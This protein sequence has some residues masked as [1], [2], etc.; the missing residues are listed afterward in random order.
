MK[1][2]FFLLWGVSYVHTRH[3]NPWYYTHSSLSFSQIMHS[4]YLTQGVCICFRLKQSCDFNSIQDTAHI[5]VFNTNLYSIQICQLRTLARSKSISNVVWL[6]LCLHFQYMLEKSF[7]C[8]I[9]IRLWVRFI[10]S[11]FGFTLYQDFKLL[12]K[13]WYF[14]LLH[15]S[16]NC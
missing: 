5:F 16:T 13:F 8:H 2:L 3:N 15:M 10:T 14:L 11:T 7:G 4:P 12:Y 6:L 1:Y 9:S